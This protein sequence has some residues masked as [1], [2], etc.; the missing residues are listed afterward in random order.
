MTPVRTSW[1]AAIA[2]AALALAATPLALASAGHRGTPKATAA[3]GEGNPL[4]MGRR[5]PSVN[6]LLTLGRATQLISNAD[7]E[8]LRFSNKSSGKNAAALI[9]G[10]RTPADGAAC[11]I[12]SNLGSGPA[13][14]WQVQPT[15]PAVGVF[16]F[17]ADIA[18]LVDKPPFEVNGTATVK[19]LSA[20]AVDG[21][22]S[23]QLQG[24]FGVVSFVAGGMP[25]LRI[26]PTFSS[27]DFRTAKL[28]L[29]TDGAGGNLAGQ[30][31]V[32]VSFPFRG[33]FATPRP[34]AIAAASPAAVTD[35]DKIIS[36]HP[37]GGDF[38]LPAG[39]PASTDAVVFVYDISDAGP[40][41]GSYGFFLLF[42]R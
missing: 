39:C 30:I 26:D 1:R 3:A 35:S 6:V 36:V 37:V 23:T 5:N 21:L 40:P 29:R 16:R 2:V 41:A 34:G 13:G 7:E 27:E 22:D 8:T 31:C 19:N 18:T 15:A 33:V 25:E 10:C 24:S 11:Q 42:K 28:S 17:G 32:D 38:N 4:L 20:D 14:R 9:D 12:A